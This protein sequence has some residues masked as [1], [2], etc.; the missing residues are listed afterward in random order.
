MG[1]ILYFDF[2]LNLW[3][4]N[5]VLLWRLAL[6][7]SRPYLNNCQAQPQIQLSW[8]ELALFSIPP[9][10]RPAG[11]PAVRTSSE[12]ASQEAEIQHVSFF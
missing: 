11:R 12:I 1:A 3:G 7:G 2:S 5:V 9:A 10:T 8:A 4:R 6:M